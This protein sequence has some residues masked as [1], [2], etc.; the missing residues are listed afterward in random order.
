M[1]YLRKIENIN[2]VIKFSKYNSFKIY[3]YALKLASYKK[4]H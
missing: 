4:N 2:S 3:F 1:L